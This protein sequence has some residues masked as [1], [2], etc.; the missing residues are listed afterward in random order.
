[1]NKIVVGCRGCALVLVGKGGHPSLQMRG[2]VVAINAYPPARSKLPRDAVR[3]M[4]IKHYT[5][6]EYLTFRRYREPSAKERET[7]PRH[8]V[9]PR[10]VGL[11]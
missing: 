5:D 2:I 3:V 8:Q 9:V 7:D 1:L 10:F 6:C 4:A 11:L